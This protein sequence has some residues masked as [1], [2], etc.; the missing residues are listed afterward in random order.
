MVV[1]DRLHS[2]SIHLLRRLQRQDVTTGLSAAR[3][4]ALSVLVFGGPMT[5]GALAA[6]QQVRPPTISRVVDALEQDG[7]AAREADAS[8]RRVIRVRATDQGIAVLEQGR[9][10]RLEYLAA[11]LQGLDA[12]QLA[13]LGE[14][15]DLIEAVLRDPA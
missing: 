11:R 15:A 3:L 5:L 6:A 1:A 14:A 4:S 10:A 9:G 8:D 7:L 2:A 12:R 13:V